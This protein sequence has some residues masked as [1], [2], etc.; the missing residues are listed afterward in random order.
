MKSTSTSAM[1]KPNMNLMITSKEQIISSY[2]DIF[3]GIGKFLGL[4]YH[5]QVVTNITPKQTPCRPIAIH[6]KWAFKKEIDKMLKA[7]IIKPVQEATPWINS[8]IHIEGKDKSGNLKLCICL[9]PTYL[10]K[11]IIWELYHFKTPEDIAHLIADSCIMMVWDCKKGYWHQELDEAL[12]LLTTFNT[13]LGRFQYTVMPFSITV[14]GDIF[15]QQLDHC[16]GHIKNVI[17]IADNI[18]VVGKKQNHRDH[19]LA[20]TVLLETIRWCK[21]LTELH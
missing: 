8:F 19:D 7:G 2:P 14:A 21:S 9:D 16:F 12:Y 10:N 20:L 6:L 3:D 5:I 15:Q 1:Q 17:I 11:A 18:M 4:P 13:K